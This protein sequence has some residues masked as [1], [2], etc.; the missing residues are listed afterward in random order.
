MMVLRRARGAAST[1]VRSQVGGMISWRRWA[2]RRAWEVRCQ[3]AARLAGAHLDIDVADD[4]AVASDVDVV[5]RPG[6]RN[7]LAI[8]GGSRID[9][10]VLLQLDG[11]T[12]HL[13]PATHLRRG[14]VLNVAG[15]LELQGS[16]I[17]SWGTT[18]HCA[19][20]VL[21]EPLASASE[22][23]TVTD[24]RHFHTTPDAFFYHHTESAP[25]RIGRNT[26]LASKSTVLMG[27]QLGGSSVLGAHSVFQGTAPDDSLLVGAPARRAR[28]A[29]RGVVREEVG[30]R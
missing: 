22:H 28:A 1:L 14:V 8:A 17:L 10:G 23:V 30:R 5:C 27:S 7:H 19:D 12:V 16:N 13:G 18:V 21:F 24:S 2:R 11:G 4:V 9:Q 29:S 6:T 3:L 25:V 15:R 20:H 26:W